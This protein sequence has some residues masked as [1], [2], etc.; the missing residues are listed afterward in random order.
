M[1]PFDI[2]G[3]T[4]ML[5]GFQKR[6]EELKAE[7]ARTQVTGEAGGG[8]VKVVATGENRIVSVSISAA[9]MDDRELLEDLVRAAANEALRQAQAASGAKLS[10]LASMLPMPPGLRP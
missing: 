2:D 4:D 8:A 1:N 10:E 9:A 7:A 5:G 6:M 3:L